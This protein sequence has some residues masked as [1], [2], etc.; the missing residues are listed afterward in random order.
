MSDEGKTYIC[1]KCGAKVG[2]NQFPFC[3]GNPSDHGPWSGAEEPC[4]EFFAEHMST[5]GEHY[6]SKRAWVHDMDKRG[7]EP[8][9][10]RSDPVPKIARGSTGKL[11]FLD[12]GKR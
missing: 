9:K 6:T 10:F 4:E 5:D 3:R 12:L 2:I 1:E 11:M 7:F 8:A